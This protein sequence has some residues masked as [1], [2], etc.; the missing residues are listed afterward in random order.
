VA[1]SSGSTGE[2]AGRYWSDEDESA[3]LDI[4][5]PFCNIEMSGLVQAPSDVNGHMSR[6]SCVSRRPV[7]IKPADSMQAIFI[8]IG[9][10]SQ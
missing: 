2:V 10:P 7:L 8:G 1:S 5:N 6:P 9:D 4:R 3:A